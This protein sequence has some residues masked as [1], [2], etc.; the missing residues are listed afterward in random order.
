MLDKI[1]IYN[2]KLMVKRDL[3]ASEKDFMHDYSVYSFKLVFAR[4]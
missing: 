4:T 2:A 1:F 3:S